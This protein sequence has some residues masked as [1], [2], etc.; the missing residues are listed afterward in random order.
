MKRAYEPLLLELLVEFPCVGLFGPRQCGKTTLLQSLPEGWRRYDLERGA[1]LQAVTNDPDLFFR[2]N[3][4]RVAIDECQVVPELFPALRVAID[5]RRQER[6]RFVI[7]GSSSPYL[8][9]SISESLAGRIA[10]IEMAPLSWSEVSAHD[11]PSLAALICDRSVEPADVVTSLKPRGTVRQAHEYWFWGGYPEPW[12]RGSERFRSRWQEQYVHTYLERDV[13]QLFPGLDRNRFRL[14]LRLLGGLSGRVLNYS[15]VARSLGV[16]QPTV[17]DYF[18]IAH[19]T[20]IWRRLPSFEHD[21]CKRV[22]KHPKGYLRDSG[23]LHHL[24]RIP[25]LD[26]LLAHPQAGT[27]WEG[28]VIEELLR[29]LSALGVSFEPFFYRTAG[30]AEVDCVLEGN[31]G[32][33]PVE[34]KYGSA[35][36]RRE[37]R[38][39]RDFMSEH[40]C[41]LGVVVNN[42]TVPR[43]LEE[44]VLGVPF[45]WL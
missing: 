31:F 37:L 24:L 9:R 39:L 43:L 27:S 5:D 7:T 42:D 14:F 4:G 8:M 32:L 41:R 10:V 18:D 34:V 33:V 13:A 30:G 23:L 38:P 1:D 15:E 40:G 20:F 35:V 44:R 28:M 22:V 11:D 29:Q 2:L 19:G 6:G 16:S 26:A 36:D 45:S 17:R 3:P 25:D 21:V 12:L